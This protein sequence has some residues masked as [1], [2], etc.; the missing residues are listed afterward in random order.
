MLTRD[1]NKAQAAPSYS[2]PPVVRAVKVLRHIAAGKSLA[3]HS[4]AAREIGINRTTLLR[5][6]HTLEAEG[7][8][9]RVPNSEEYALG[10]GMIEFAAQKLH[11]LDL[12]KV[13]RPILSQLAEKVGLSA[14]LGI[15]EKREVVY[16]VRAAPDA[17]LVSN[18]RIGTR[19]PAHAS[20][21]GRT[22][23]AHMPRADVEVLYRGV[24][25]FSVTDK[26]PTTLRQLHAQLDQIRAAGLADSR[27]A[28]EAGIDAISAP[29][30]DHSGS[31]AGAINAS[32]P[33]NAFDTGAGRRSEIARAVLE[34]AAEISRRL[35]WAATRP[36]GARI[37]ETSE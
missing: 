3:N 23:L 17:H 30:F 24:E 32:G 21:L 28:F 16:I 9:E 15:L 10:P 7:L 25:L 29:V 1:A 31:V 37:L 8:I 27:S 36:L 11:S 33:E 34:A 13:A 12:A 35:G 20:S 4:Q 26:T 18:I 14:H 19:L 22:I 2:V 5:L 6:L